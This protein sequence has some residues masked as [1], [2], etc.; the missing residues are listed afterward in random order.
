MTPHPSQ[1]TVTAWL[2][3][4]GMLLLYP[5]LKRIPDHEW[6]LALN[7][8]RVLPLDMVELIGILAGVVLVSWMLRDWTP[9]ADVVAA[10]TL[11]VMRFLLA[12]PLLALFVGPFLLR[13]TRRGLESLRQQRDSS[14]N[15]K[16]YLKEVSHE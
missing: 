4:Q 2:K 8:A 7:R 10:T 16:A 15:A 1:R 13:R 9:A 14:T 3:R 12:I 5:D 6:P 11:N